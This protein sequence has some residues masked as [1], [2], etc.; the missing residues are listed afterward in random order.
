MSLKIRLD[1]LENRANLD[2][3]IVAI[4][5]RPIESDA[6]LESLVAG[7]NVRGGP[8]YIQRTPMTLQEWLASVGLG[9]AA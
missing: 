5:D 2:G 4:V 8:C 9:E 1:R 6:E 7:T 3:D